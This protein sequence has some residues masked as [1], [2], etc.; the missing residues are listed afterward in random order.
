MVSTLLPLSRGAVGGMPATASG[1]AAMGRGELGV[2]SVES[3]WSMRGEFGVWREWGELGVL[4]VWCG[5]D[6]GS[7]LDS[8]VGVVEAPAFAGDAS[9]RAF[10]DLASSTRLEESITDTAPRQTKQQRLVKHEAPNAY[11]NTQKFG[12]QDVN[13]TTEVNSQI[14]SKYRN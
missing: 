9:K 7:G 4:A 8:V 11:G 1:T 6:G 3:A 2:W 12:V 10:K 13:S 14:N 5:G